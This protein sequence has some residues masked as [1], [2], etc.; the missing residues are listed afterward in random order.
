MEGE[1]TVQRMIR[2]PLEPL[3]VLPAFS[4]ALFVLSL[5]VGQLACLV[6]PQLSEQCLLSV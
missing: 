2:C 3:S 1:E 6:H 5:Q 4:F